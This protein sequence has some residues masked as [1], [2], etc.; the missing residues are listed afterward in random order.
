MCVC[1]CFVRQHLFVYSF[2]SDVL[3]TACSG[4]KAHSLLIHMC[5]KGVHSKVGVDCI[6]FDAQKNSI[7]FLS[8]VCPSVFSFSFVKLYLSFI[9]YFSHKSRR[10][11]P[12]P[13]ILWSV[14]VS[15][16][17]ISERVLRDVQCHLLWS[18][19]PVLHFG[20]WRGQLPLIASLQRWT[21]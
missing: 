7:H 9:F 8:A 6:Q 19:E 10:L 1:E 18:A 12:G 21:A 13:P 3:E 16:I 20:V 2:F 5:N 14:G 4:R 15:H 11:Y 17:I